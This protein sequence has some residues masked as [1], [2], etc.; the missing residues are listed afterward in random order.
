M[1]AAWTSESLVLLQ[2]YTAS[3]HRTPRNITAEK[4]SKLG[5]VTPFMKSDPGQQFVGDREN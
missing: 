4:T 5:F 1:E 3:R 2:H